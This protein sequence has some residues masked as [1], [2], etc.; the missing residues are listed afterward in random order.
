M[1][2]RNGRSF[3]AWSHVHFLGRFSIPSAFYVAPM[4]S[5]RRTFHVKHGVFVSRETERARPAYRSF[6]V[7]QSGRRRK[8]RARR[9]GGGPEF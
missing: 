8:A 4:R 9:F 6:H 1:V 5:H 7:K 2:R 3:D